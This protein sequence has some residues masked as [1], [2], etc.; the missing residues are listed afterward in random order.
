MTGTLYV[1]PSTVSAATG[2]SAGCRSGSGD[3]SGHRIE[4]LRRGSRRP[5]RGSRLR[6][7][8]W[9]STQ[10][11]T[12][13][14]TKRTQYFQ[15]R[16]HA[17]SWFNAAVA[18]RPKGLWAATQIIDTL[19]YK[20]NKHSVWLVLQQYMNLNNFG[21]RACIVVAPA[22]PLLLI[23]PSTRR[24]Q[25]H[26]GTP[27]QPSCMSS[28]AIKTRMFRRPFDTL[29]TRSPF[30]AGREG[31]RTGTRSDGHHATD[32]TARSKHLIQPTTTYR[33]NISSTVCRTS[34]A[35]R[36]I[37]PFLRSSDQIKLSSRIS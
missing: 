26:C 20:G 27:R 29:A 23:M 7:L 32:L 22:L 25:Q 5:T 33:S 36:Y 34:T 6:S 19:N 17:D 8:S 2:L 37:R 16:L 13:R 28:R 3:R 10:P 15:N 35:W 21:T 1:G 14:L 31:P 4:G 18:D 12:A 24:P 30:A 11:S 9:P